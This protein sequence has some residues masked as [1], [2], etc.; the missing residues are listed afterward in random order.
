METLICLYLPFSSLPSEQSFS[1]SHLY[2]TR[3]Q[4]LLDSHQNPS[5]C[6]HVVLVQ[7]ARVPS[8]LKSRQSSSPSHSHCLPMQFLL[9]HLVA[10]QYEEIILRKQKL[11]FVKI[12]LKFQYNQ[13]T[14]NHN[15]RLPMTYFLTG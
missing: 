2:S 4:T 5:F 3:I 6:R 15:F 9:S 11:K 7:L 14:T 1:P 10:M 12:P 13:Y 8:S